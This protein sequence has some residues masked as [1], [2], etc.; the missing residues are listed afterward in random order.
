MG[1]MTHRDMILVSKPRVMGIRNITMHTKSITKCQP[2]C[3]PRWP[4]Y[5]GPFTP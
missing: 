2:S 3:F 4:P 1:V 5:Y